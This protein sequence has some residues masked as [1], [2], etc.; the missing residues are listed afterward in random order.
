MPIPFRV[1]W[2]PMATMAPLTKLPVVSL[3]ESRKLPISA[4]SG[5]FGRV[6][7]TRQDYFTHF[8]QSQSLGGAKTGD[9]REKIKALA[10]KISR[11]CP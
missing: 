7:T 9:C 8:E 10:T 2:S 6:F 4:Q 1:L 11:H 3:V 5:F